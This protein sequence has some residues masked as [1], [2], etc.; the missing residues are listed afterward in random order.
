MTQQGKSKPDST[1]RVFGDFKI[2]RKITWLAVYT[3]LYRK[4]HTIWHNLPKQG[5]PKINIFFLF[6]LS[7][8]NQ[9]QKGR[10]TINLYSFLLPPLNPMSNTWEG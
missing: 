8:L 6:I 7:F 3:S 1:K 5:K 9:T 4:A 2:A 10:F